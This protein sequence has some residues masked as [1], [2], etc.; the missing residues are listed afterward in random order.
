MSLSGNDVQLLFI[1]QAVKRTDELLR[2]TMTLIRG[3]TIPRE[4]FF[5]I[6]RHTPSFS[7]HGS[8]KILCFH[9][10]LLCRFPK[11]FFG[12]RKIL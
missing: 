7:M 1:H 10:A 11:P 12:R 6:L 3:F 4:G 5:N 2:L 8:E 9:V